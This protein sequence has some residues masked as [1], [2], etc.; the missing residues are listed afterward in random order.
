MTKNIKKTF[1]PA[2]NWAYVP[3]NDICSQN[4]YAPQKSFVDMVI[5][6]NISKCQIIM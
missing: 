2:W 4:S 5:I 6:S 1:P 3:P